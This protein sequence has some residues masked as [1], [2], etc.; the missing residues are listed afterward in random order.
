MAELGYTPGD[1]LSWDR[2]EQMR[3]E[4]NADLAEA[5][6]AFEA[7]LDALDASQVA[8]T[9]AAPADWAGSPPETLQ[10]AVDRLVA[11]VTTVS[12]P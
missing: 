5:R 12:P 6:A 2:I 3:Q 11:V 8:Y 7:S 10:D 9:A 1:D 4:I